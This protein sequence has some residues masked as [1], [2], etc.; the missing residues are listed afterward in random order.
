MNECRAG[1]ER[2]TDVP[3]LTGCLESLPAGA[4]G[5][6]F[7]A[8]GLWVVFTSPGAD[9]PIVVFLLGLLL[10]HTSIMAIV[11]FVLKRAVR[12]LAISWV[13]FFGG[14]FDARGR[15]SQVVVAGPRRSGRQGPTRLQIRI[16]PRNRSRVWI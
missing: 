13:A 9:R 2:D 8:L 6:A 11:G 10:V 7:A 3:G 4:F 16:R 15:V 5:V 14:V 12:L 1:G